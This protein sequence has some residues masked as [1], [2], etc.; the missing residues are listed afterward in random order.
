MT[1]ADASFH[2]ARAVFRRRR[3]ACALALVALLLGAAA[4]HAE[5]DPRPGLVAL[6]GDEQVPLPA[7]R[8][9][10]D[11]RIQGDLA[12]VI[13]TQVFENPYDEPLHARYIF[14]LPSDAAVYAMRL[15]SG[16]QMIE[17]EIRPKQEARA[18]FE[19]AKKRGNQ[20]ALLDQQ[21]P[22][23]FTQEVA[24]LLPKAPVRVVLEYAHAIPK[25][26]GSYHFHVP[27]VV[28]PRFLREALPGESAGAP[29]REPGEPEPLEVGAWNL[30]ASPPLAAPAHVDRERVGLHVEIDAGMPILGLESRSHR[31]VVSRPDP[32]RRV[33]ELAE[34][35][36][37]D[38]RDFELDYR[39]EGERVAAGLTAFA[40]EGDDAGGG[41]LSLLL[42]PPAHVAEAAITPR[43]MVYVL[44]CSGSMAGTPLA[45]S[46]R[47][48][49]R[50]LRSLRPSDSFR[51]IRFSDSANQWSEAPVAATPASIAA[52]QTYLDSLSGGGG[53][54]MASGIRAA[55]APPGEPGVLRLVV[56]LTDGYIGN[57]IE[58][59]RLI[60]QMRGDARLFSFGIGSSVNR[61]LIQ[62]MARSG[63]GTARIVHPGEDAEVAADEL[64]RRLESPVL[65]DIE[66]DWG[67]ARVRDAFPRQIPDL[68]LGQTVRVMARYLAP[69]RHRITVHGRLAGRPVSLPLDVDL[70]ATRDDARGSALP[71]LW[72]RSQIEDRMVEYLAPG[73]DRTERDGI[74]QE[75]TRL[76]LAHRLVTQWTSFVAV[77]KPVVNP[78]GLGR[79]ADVAV[80]QAKDVPDTAYPASA[81]P[82]SSEPPATAQPAPGGPAPTLVASNAAPPLQAVTGSGFQGQAGPEPST[83]FGLLAIA[84]AG[85]VVR[86]RRTAAHS[87]RRPPAARLGGAS[88]LASWWS[89]TTRT[90]GR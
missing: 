19:S 6:L 44:D 69:G 47:F 51:I 2:G 23:V 37:L 9:D 24:N 65:R 72:A 88:W 50:S 21:R 68:F 7:L 46:K 14:P 31:I 82:A 28:G 49:R 33:V 30:P 12:R 59:V 48:A 53:T 34:G 5:D 11:A 83:W 64:A 42:E 90:S 77:A 55:L 16:D 20:A 56:F 10:V 45:A 73:L 38:D 32:T 71:I 84:L 27:L 17:A 62:E 74:E 89:T 36:T 57:D 8:V 13:L 18:V 25:D 79:T 80:P 4:V 63:R 1:F 40:G 39:L 67:A 52:G 66:V 58:I 76:G 60:Q 3:C 87:R 29:T 81:L 26:Q 15:V 70:P 61:Y 54:E 22:N 86:A 41:H 43:E 85:G 75:V 78:G 35:R